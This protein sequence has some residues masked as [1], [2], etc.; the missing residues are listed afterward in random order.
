M[1]SF[2]TEYHVQPRASF[3]TLVNDNRRLFAE[4]PTTVYGG[5]LNL[6]G[7][8][9]VADALHS[10]VLDPRV[11]LSRFQG[12]SDLNRDE[13]F[14]DGELGKVL[15]NGRLALAGAYSDTSTLTSELTDTGLFSTNKSRISYLL[16]PSYIH[17]FTPALSF[18]ISGSVNDVEFEDSEETGFVNYTNYVLGTFLQYAISDRTSLYSTNFGDNI[19]HT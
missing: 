8:L 2:A 4:N 15:K 9:Y 14:F 10:A 1:S 3:K 7:S 18:S 17:F 19:R 13:Y 16:A 5:V 6:G 11:R 12:D